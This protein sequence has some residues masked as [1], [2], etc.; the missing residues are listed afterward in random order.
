MKGTARGESTAREDRH[1]HLPGDGRG[2][3]HGSA[4]FELG[5]CIE[6]RG[7]EAADA[8]AVSFASTS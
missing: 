4:G 7:G 1:G 2:R 3:R 6:N 5:Q 8:E